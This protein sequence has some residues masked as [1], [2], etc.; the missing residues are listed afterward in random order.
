M[1][2]QNEFIKLIDF[3]IST[4]QSLMYQVQYQMYIDRYKKIIVNLEELKTVTQKGTLAT[5]FIYLG[6]TQMLDHND[7]KQLEDAILAINKFYCDN[8]RKLT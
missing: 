8:Y 4:V 7:P 6:V 5:S 2:R 3:G 1:D